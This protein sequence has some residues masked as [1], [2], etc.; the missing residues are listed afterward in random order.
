[1]IDL[2]LVS[3]V[4]DT[5][6]V[7]SVLRRRRAKNIARKGMGERGYK[8]ERRLGGILPWGESIHIEIE[9]HSVTARV[10]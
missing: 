2:S 9:R 10:E 7:Q 6:S 4:P 8:D 1:L 3:E 5:Q